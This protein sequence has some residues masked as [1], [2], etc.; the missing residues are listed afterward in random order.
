MKEND[1]REWEKNPN[2]LGGLEDRI[3]VAE[4]KTTLPSEKEIEEKIRK[5]E[6]KEGE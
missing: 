3:F 4:Y 2:A 6:W 5:I 1:K